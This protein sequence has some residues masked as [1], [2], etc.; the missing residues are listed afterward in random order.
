MCTTPPADPSSP[1]NHAPGTSMGNAPAYMQKAP[2]LL[3]CYGEWETDTLEQ[4]GCTWWNTP[5]RPGSAGARAM[6]QAEH[7]AGE[8]FAA[9][10]P[11]QELAE[12]VREFD[13]SDFFG[14]GN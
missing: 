2:I 4:A 13:G 3:T 7:R 1:G 6:R 5:P 12:W 10:A 9:S 14:P 8:E 11:G